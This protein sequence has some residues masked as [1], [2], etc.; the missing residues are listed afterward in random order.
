MNI[1]HITPHMGGG[2]GRVLMNYFAAAPRAGGKFSL[3]CLDYIND[4]ARAF[5]EG[6]GIEHHDRLGRDYGRLAALMA[7]ADVTVVHFWNHPLLYDFI[8][9]GL[10][11]EGRALFWSHVSGH[12]APQVF[13]GP[14][15]DFPD[16]FAFTTPHSFTA[17]AVR[18]LS[19]GEKAAKIRLLNNCG[20]L[21]YVG[22]ARRLHHE[23]FRVGYVGTV[24]YQK[25]SNIGY[26]G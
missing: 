6:A 3:H 5:M 14:L 22:P 9:N 8:L 15:L 20:G 11:P 18:A 19:E 17:P 23:R 7:K 24:D 2:V 13:T 4:K 25:M 12:S 26:P 16:L 21:D 10:W 1:L